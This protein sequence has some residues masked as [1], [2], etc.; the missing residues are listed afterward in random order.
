MLAPMPFGNSEAESQKDSSAKPRVA[1]NELPWEKC[2]EATNPNGVA[3]LR[4]KPAATPSGLKS[5]RQA[6]QGSSFLAT[7]GWRTQ[8]RWDSR[9]AGFP[10]LRLM[11]LLRNSRKALGLE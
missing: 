8:S 1:K 6:T 4:R 2:V 11:L 7:L 3:V 9:T 10:A 5:M